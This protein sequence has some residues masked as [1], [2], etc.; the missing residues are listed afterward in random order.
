MDAPLTSFTVLS[1]YGVHNGVQIA[2]RSVFA[3]SSA[4]AESQCLVSGRCPFAKAQ[5]IEV[6][7]C[8]TRH[9][10]V[11]LVSTNVIQATHVTHLC[12]GVEAEP[13]ARHTACTPTYE[14]FCPPPLTAKEIYR[15]K[16]SWSSSFGTYGNFKEAGLD[17][18][19]RCVSLSYFSVRV[20]NHSYSSTKWNNILYEH[21]TVNGVIF[22]Q[23]N[24]PETYSSIVLVGLLVWYC[25]PNSKFI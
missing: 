23:I 16:T 17:T 3:S 21:V 7:E 9:T 5:T 1:K 25:N 22:Y 4:S 20:D 2:D 14:V 6:G 24:W 10:T 15:L 18:F 12:A 13:S 8:T 11:T 19:I